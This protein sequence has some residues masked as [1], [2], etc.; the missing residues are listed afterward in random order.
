[1]GLYLLPKS[2]N[3]LLQVDKNSCFLNFKEFLELKL[4]KASLPFLRTAHLGK[5][6]HNPY[7]T[8]RE[9]MLLARFC[10]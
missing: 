3:L 9:K 5:Y 8:L 6:T 10:P 7:S 2:K 1:M 4:L